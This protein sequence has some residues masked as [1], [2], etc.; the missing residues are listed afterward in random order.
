L[1]TN[2]Q[3][4]L[5][6]ARQKIELELLIIDLLGFSSGSAS[7]GSGAGKAATETRS[8]KFCFMNS[9]ISPSAHRVKE[10]LVVAILLHLISD[11][12]ISWRKASIATV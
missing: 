3:V 4:R 8:P 11:A 6:I 7:A 1:I 9:V 10:K 5:D 2:V 12:E